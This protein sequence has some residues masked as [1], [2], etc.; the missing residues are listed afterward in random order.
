MCEG[1]GEG[2]SGDLWGYTHVQELVQTSSSPSQ[3][4]PAALEK[5]INQG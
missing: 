5:G 4:L 1:W 3:S 2:K